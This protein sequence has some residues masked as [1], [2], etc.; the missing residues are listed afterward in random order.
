MKMFHFN[1]YTK[2]FGQQTEMLDPHIIQSTGPGCSSN[3]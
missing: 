3:G 2:G 1:G